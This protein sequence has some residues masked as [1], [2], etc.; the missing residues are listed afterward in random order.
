M[1]GL[2]ALLLVSA[3]ARVESVSLT[4][5]GSRLA[6]WVALS[7]APGMVAVHREGYVARVSITGADLGLRVAG[8][9]RFSWTPSDGFDPALLAASPAKLDRLEIAATPSEVSL[10]LHVPSD[11]S[12]DVRRDP[13]GLLVVFRE[14][15][16]E[17][18][19]ERVALPV[20]A[21]P[22]VPP[23]VAEAT[24]TPRMEAALA[25]PSPPPAAAPSPDTTELARRLLLPP[26]AENEPGTTASVVELYPH[27]FPTGPVQTLPEEAHPAEAIEEVQEAGLAVG[28][29]RVRA[30]LDARY[31]DADTFVESF[32]V[33]T[34]DRYL[35]VQPRVAAAAPVG[36]GHLTL[37]YAPVFRAFATHDDINRSSHVLGAGIDLPV[38]GRT[39]LRAQDRF[40]S[41]VLDTRVVDPGAE[42]FFGLGHFRRN[43]VDAGA[44][45]MIGPR[46]SVELAGAA[47]MVRFQEESTFF[48]YDTRRASAG[49]GFELTPS[50]KAVASYVYD[51]VPRPDQRPE[52]EA[53]AHS[54]QVALGG[55]LLPLLT[56]D[57]AVAY[58]NQDSPNAGPGGTGYSGLTMSARLVRQLGREATLAVS[59]S[60]STPVSAYEENAFYVFT[61]V[62]G[63]LQVPLPARLQLRGGVGYQW[64]DYRTVASDIGRPRADRVLGWYVGLR[65]PVRDNFFLSAAYRSEDRWSN[66]DAFDTDADGFYFQLEWDIFGAAPR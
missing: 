55:E 64:N 39:T 49:F 7:G 66:V 14:A 17:T 53:S 32:A 42:Y 13:R 2:A 1:N 23:P 38:G 65:R 6:V 59:A 4:T 28:P 63:T 61:V 8:G 12:V 31:M 37:D 20:A 26:P 52:A 60:R 40:H 50:L 29:F 57:L 16:A 36:E 43:D 45:I 30:S 18:V 62:Q 41:G 46:L 3:F 48:D 35:E 34:R 54:A 22:I 44:S 47:G 33:P 5:V 19:P 15:P 21:A 27:L 58:R 24:V 9:R 11:V 25:P 56:G 51:A 10:L